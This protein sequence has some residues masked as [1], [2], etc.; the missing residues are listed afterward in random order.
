MS[1]TNNPREQLAIGDKV[2]VIKGKYEGMEGTV[3][4]MGYGT[5][6]VLVETEGRSKPGFAYQPS[7]YPFIRDELQKVTTGDGARDA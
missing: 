7:L 1:Y 2:T 5:F 3:H 4:E 6:F